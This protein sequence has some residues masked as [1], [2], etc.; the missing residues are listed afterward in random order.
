[1][2]AIAAPRNPLATTIGPSRAEQEGPAAVSNDSLEVT[3]VPWASASTGTGSWE[4]A[5]GHPAHARAG[6]VYRDGDHPFLLPSMLKPESGPI[7][8]L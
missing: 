5:G 1:V 6:A 8:S 7:Y 4:R 3:T 2:A